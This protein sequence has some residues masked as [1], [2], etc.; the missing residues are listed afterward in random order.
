MSLKSTA[1]ISTATWRVVPQAG[2]KSGL[3]ASAEILNGTCRILGRGTSATWLYYNLKRSYCKVKIAKMLKRKEI[4]FMKGYRIHLVRHGMTDANLNGIYIGS[5]DEPL[6]SQG[7]GELYEKL[8]K[9]VYPGVQ[10]VYS[11]PLKRCLSTAGILFPEAFTVSVEDLR[12]MDF[13]EY[14]GKKAI[15]LMNDPGY[16][17][18]LKGGLDNPPPGGESIR[19]VIERS[20]VGISYVVSD[21]MREGLTNCAVVTHGGIIMNLLSCFGIPK[22][23]PMQF[24]CDFGEGYEILVTADMWMRSHAFEILG[25]FPL[26]RSK[27]D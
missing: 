12:E 25:K 18:F 24:P 16:K 17:E 10:K 22:M 13:G 1:T 7:V 21:M 8:D 26:N 23:P 2:L 20:Y 11:S 19:H 5:T 14:E 15:D 27:D 4:N 3:T 9:M 6:C